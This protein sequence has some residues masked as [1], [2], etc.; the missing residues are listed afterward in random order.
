MEKEKE[1]TVTDG[2]LVGLSPEDREQHLIHT[3]KWISCWQVCVVGNDRKASKTK[4]RGTDHFW[5]AQR[6]SR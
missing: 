4:E 3:I 2:F 5:M 6:T 1:I